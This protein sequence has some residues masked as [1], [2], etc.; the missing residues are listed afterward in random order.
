MTS[1]IYGT[2]WKEDKTQSLTQAALE[3]GFRG[4]DT[5]NQRKHYF[6][7]AVGAGVSAFLDKTPSVLRK[8]LFLQTKFTYQR[9][10]DHRLPYDPKSPVAVQVRQSFASSL[11]HLQTDY[12]DSYLLHGPFSGMDLTEEDHQ[13]WRVL[14]ELH[15][16]K[17]VLKIGVS[18]FSLEQL[19][20]LFGFAKTPP[21]FIQNR[22]FARSGWDFHIRA[23]C[24]QNKM[25]YQGFS[26][27]TANVNELESPVIDSIAQ[28]YDAT[29]PQLVFRFSQQVG[30]I[31][32]TGTTDPTHMREDLR[33]G[34]DLSANDIEQIERIG[35][36]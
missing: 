16:E 35:L 25:S 26:L 3:A 20:L 23:F 33:T 4:I 1:L 27:L 18:N 9:G 24:R 22:C 32:L 31:P 5:A 13:V 34:F 28:K 17:R 8:D 11:Q 2:A 29:L 6:E 21:A 12:L 14:E 7:E 36:R 30:M 15:A 10:Q 19:E